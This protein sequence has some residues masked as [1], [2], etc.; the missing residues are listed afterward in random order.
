M[1]DSG[2][3]KIQVRGKTKIRR[4]NRRRSDEGTDGEKKYGLYLFFVV[5]FVIFYKKDT[6]QW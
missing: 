4:G 6:S 5:S 1:V 2:C 3:K